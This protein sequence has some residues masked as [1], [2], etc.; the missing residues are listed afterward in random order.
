MS[1]RVELT[2]TFG[3]EANYS[4]VRRAIV[5]SPNE[6][7]QNA[8]GRGNYQK[9]VMRR[10]KASVG[11]NGVRGV[12]TSY[13]DGYAFRPYGLCQVMFVSWEY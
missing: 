6:G 12:T 3:G 2:D 9:T 11:M 1:Y 4:W 13:G 10:A 8:Q 7:K 5:E